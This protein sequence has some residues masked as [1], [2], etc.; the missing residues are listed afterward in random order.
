MKAKQGRFF[1]GCTGYPTCKYS[2]LVTVELVEEYFYHENKKGMFCKRCGYSLT[3][4]LGRNG[5]YV[6]CGDDPP[7]TFS[8][9]EI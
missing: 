9:D 2:E 8:L 6:I 1:L 5:V 7:H 4:K 3:A